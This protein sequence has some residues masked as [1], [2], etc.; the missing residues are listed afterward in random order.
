[1]ASGTSRLD[2]DG[3][4]GMM[5]AESAAAAAAWR[6]RTGGRIIGYMGT[7]VPVEIIDAAGLYPVRI[8]IGAPAVSAAAR[9]FERG[10]SD[11]VAQL[12]EPLLDGSLS[13]LDHLVI[14]NT[15][16]FNLAVFHFLREARRRDPALPAPPISLHEFHHGGDAAAAAYNLD[17]CVRLG[18]AMEALGSR[19]TDQSIGDAIARANGRRAGA[20]RLAARRRSEPAAI[21]GTAALRSLVRAQLLPDEAL[22]IPPGVAPSGP[23]V[24]FSGSDIDHLD[25]YPLIEEAGCVIAADDHDW[26]EQVFDVPVDP[27]GDVFAAIARRY[28]NRPPRAARWPMQERIDAV[29]DRAVQANVQGAI[30]WISDEDHASN[31]DLPRLIAALH[32]RGIATLN[33]GPQPAREVDAPAILERIAEWLD[34]LTSLSL[35][36]ARS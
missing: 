5:L 29:V 31:W 36:E 19:I 18:G 6:D 4:A 21:S 25:H 2:R 33:L 9:Y 15:P 8:G 17:A 10:D 24:L 23:R 32:T 13:F 7:D 20:A 12:V 14:G 22:V 1:M 34:T 35:Q 28:A 26:G 3:E 27:E 30:F 16:V 11:V